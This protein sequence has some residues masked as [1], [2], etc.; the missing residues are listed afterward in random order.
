MEKGVCPFMNGDEQEPVLGATPIAA[1]LKTFKERHEKAKKFMC[2]LSA[3]V[4]NSMIVNI[5]DEKTPKEAWN[6]LVKLY[7]TNTT[8]RKMQLK[9]ESHNVQ[10]NKLNINENSMKLKGLVDNLGSIGALVDDENLVFVTLNGLGK[11]YAK[12]W[13]SSPSDLS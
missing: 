11:E 4:S 13:T 8:P 9:Q 3:S 7:S 2:W 1:K 10:M 12:I 5:Q 6:T